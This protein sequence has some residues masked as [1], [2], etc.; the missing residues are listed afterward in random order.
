[1]KKQTRT[2]VILWAVYVIYSFI[3]S[4]TIIISGDDYFWFHMDSFKEN[5]GENSHNGRYFTNII[6]YLM[7][8][9]D[10]PRFLVFF[11]TMI[12]LFYLL[13]KLIRPR[14]EENYTI[15]AIFI[16]FGL[17]AIPS[18]IFTYTYAWIS[19]F[20]NYVLGTVMSFVF[21]AYCYPVLQG[22]E[23]K[24]SPIS[25]VLLLIAGFLGAMCVENLTIFNILFSVFI[26]ILYAVLFKKVNIGH[27]TYLIGAVIGTVIMFTNVNYTDVLVRD[28]DSIGDRSVV[29]SL[30]DIFMKIYMEIIPYY[31][32]LFVFMH[33]IIAVSVIYLYV[34]RYKMDSEA[35]PPKYAP[36]LFGVIITYALYSMFTFCLADFV[37]VTTTYVIRAIE[38]AFVFVYIIAL[39]YMAYIFF[40]KFALLRVIVFISGTLV[41]TAP[42]LVVNPVTF[43]CFYSDYMFWLLVAGEF[44]VHFASELKPMGKVV[45]N[46]VMTSVT[47][48]FVV[49][50][51]YFSICNKICDN[52]RWDYFRQQVDEQK[53]VI[54]A[55]NLPFNVYNE[56]FITFF[57]NVEE[58]NDFDDPDRTSKYIIYM[59]EFYGIDPRDVD[60]SSIYFISLQDYFTAHSE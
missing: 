53:N 26:I 30:P 36:F 4:V 54:E 38:T 52:I 59:L 45:L 39:I 15:V 10:I 25:A 17:V 24:N 43:R 18:H 58:I 16:I 47:T 8:N 13:H 7:C 60:I 20:T 23:L 50:I 11:A 46:Y 44:F 9:Y 12:V 37:P 40:D 6:T 3:L 35:K 51:S 55:I 56:D 29:F 28:E 19:G 57:A 22:K 5:F 1:M 48:F 42:F 32:K 27:I 41:L 49:V 21:I 31:A 33:L 14:I 34:K 2:K